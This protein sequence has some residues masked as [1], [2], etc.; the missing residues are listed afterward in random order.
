MKIL[1]FTNTPSLYKKNLN[2]YNGGGW[3]ESLEA[4]IS[5]RNDIELGI[6]FYHSD[7]CFRKKDGNTTYYPL[8]LYNSKFKKIKHNLFY[9]KSDKKEVNAYLEVIN[10]FK[11]DVIHIFGSEK[12]FGLIT[13]QTNIPVIIHI[14]GLLNPCLN[15][16][17]PPGYSY[18]NQLEQYF[19]KPVKL[20][21]TLRGMSFFKYNASREDA[22]LK[23]CKHFMGRTQWDK[24]LCA[25]FAPNSKYFY[26]SETLRDLFYKATPWVKQIRNKFF[27]TSIIS[28]TTYKGFDVILKTAK[29]LREHTNIDFEWTVFGIKEYKFWEK[30][31][32]IDCASVQVK[33][34]GIA[35]SETLVNY[36]L[37]SDVFVHSSYIDNSPNSICEAQILGLPVIA[38]NVGGVSS[39]IEEGKTGVLVP[40]NDPYSFASKII[41]LFESPNKAINLGKN[42]RELALERHSRDKILIDLLGIYSE[43]QNANIT[44]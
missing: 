23:D 22:I 24:N 39:L 2:G 29:L 27:I 38:A 31:L 11:P 30:K 25:L 19:L 6:S 7:D 12:S 35:D 8:S 17:F 20:F 4:T 42:A 36:L 13:R 41:G 28:K 34:K 14:Q 16:Y 33:L 15:A 26:C 9:K 18:F 10:D 44:N 1:W 32:G 5:K 43:L 40:A 21:Q 37:A 3:I